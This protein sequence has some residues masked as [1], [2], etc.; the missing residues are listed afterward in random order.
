MARHSWPEKGHH[1][2]TNHAL[3]ELTVHDEIPNS[4]AGSGIGIALS[5]LG[6]R[7]ERATRVRT[8]VEE[9][10]CESRAREPFPDGDEASRRVTVRIERHGGNMVVS[11]T[12]FRLPVDSVSTSRLP[13][14]RLASLGF[15]DALRIVN[16]GRQGNIASATIA[17]DD[18]AFA[19]EGVEVLAADAP[20]I[21]VN[22]SDDIVIRPMTA[23]DVPGL[24]RCVYRC[25]GYS[26]PDD[27]VYKPASLRHMLRSGLMRSVVAV[28]SSGEVIGHCSLTF[29]HSLDRVPEA[30]RLVVDPRYRGHHL[31]ERLGKARN[32]IAQELALPGLWAE[33]VTNHVA[34]QRNLVALG[35]VETGLLIGV[36]PADVV[37]AGLANENEGRRALLPMFV[38]VTT[39]LPQSPDQDVSTDH[40]SGE[41]PVNSYISEHYASVAEGLAIR[42]GRHRRWLTSGAELAGRTRHFVDVN[43]GVG[44]ASIWIDHAGADLAQVIARELDALVGYELGAVHI[45]LKLND[46]MS[47][48]AIEGLESLGFCWATWIPDERVDSDV[49]RLQR[50]GEHPTDVEHI[51]CATAEGEQLRDW[52]IAQWHRVRHGQGTGS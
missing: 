5:G 35:A 52:V 12:D 44:I 41:K 46:P 25:Y 14:R 17:I 42:T 7:V 6:L 16:R 20:A 36:G 27:L 15:V 3:L 45:D 19:L 32:A 13:S 30:G 26:Y 50:V 8:V 40:E 22:D 23:T 24:I 18:E 28:D 29:A 48:A 2:E 31:A 10:I 39:A 4:A 37:M 34:S 21:D 9:L 38:P 51:H 47:P 33:C 43:V 49:L 11:V 1:D